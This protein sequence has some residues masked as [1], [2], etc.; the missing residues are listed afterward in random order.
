MYIPHLPPWPL[1]CISATSPGRIHILYGSGIFDAFYLPFAASLTSLSV[2]D[3]ESAA[4]VVG[5]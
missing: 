5:S 3:E 2:F 1:G 4:R